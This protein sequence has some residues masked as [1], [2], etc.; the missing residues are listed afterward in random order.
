MRPPSIRRCD[1]HIALSIK[2]T[3]S[4]SK[5]GSHSKFI[6]IKIRY[7]R[8]EVTYYSKIMLKCFHGLLFPN[9]AGIL[10]S[11]LVTVHSVI[12]AV[13][14]RTNNYDCMCMQMHHCPLYH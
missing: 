10:G 12:H 8:S 5:E 9:Y 14:S 13:Y 2:G 6:P 1:M 4:G 7:N 3:F 11:G